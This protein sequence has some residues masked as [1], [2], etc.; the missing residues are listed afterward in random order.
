MG[1]VALGMRLVISEDLLR[2]ARSR[3]V[4]ESF[5][6]SQTATT[7]TINDPTTTTMKNV[8]LGAHDE[9]AGGDWN[10]HMQDIG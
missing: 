10:S 7:I 8:A 3:A 5:S 6:Q 4:F 9:E 2:S 1:P